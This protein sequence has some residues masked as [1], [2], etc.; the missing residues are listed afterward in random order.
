VAE[1]T[2]GQAIEDI[3]KNYSGFRIMAHLTN[4][5]KIGNRELIF[6]VPDGN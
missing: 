4:Y 2:T 1:T 6:G 3:K 5:G